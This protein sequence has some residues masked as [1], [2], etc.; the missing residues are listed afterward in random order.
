MEELINSLKVLLADVVTFYFKAHGHHW[1]VEGDDFPQFH[2]FFGEIYEDAYGSI[3]PIAE[4]IRKCGD[5]APFRLE[6]FIE[7]RT[8]VDTNVTPEEVDMSTDLLLANTQVLATLYRAFAAATAANSQ[9]IANFLAERIDQH[10]K[11]AWQL[12]AI[13]KPEPSENGD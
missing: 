13:V 8:V 11:W 10:E 1:N 7:Y 4:N 5:Y 6:R 3:D 2:A 9:G 12:R